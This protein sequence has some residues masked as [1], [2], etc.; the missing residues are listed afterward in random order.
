MSAFKLFFS[1]FIQLLLWTI[2]PFL[3]T[4][5]QTDSLST[6]NPLPSKRKSQLLAVPFVSYSPETA[7]VFGGVGAFYF[8]LAKGDTT[9]R[10]SQIQLIA[11]SSTNGQLNFRPGWELITQNENYIFRGKLSIARFPNKNY[12]LGNDADLQVVDY[13]NGTGETLNYLRYT[14]DRYSVRNS[15]LRKIADNLY[16]GLQLEV[17][18]VY[19]YGVLADSLQYL[20]GQSEIDRIPVEGFRLGAGFNI[21]YD[22]RTNSL[23]PLNGS[24]VEFQSVFYRKW[25]GADFHYRSFSLD[26]RKYINTTQKH[27]LALQ[28]FLQHNYPKDNSNLPLRA[29]AQLGG[30]DLIRGYREGTYQDNSLTV[31]QVEYR[32]PVW[33]FIGVVGFAGVGQVYSSSNQWKWNRFRTGVGGGLR[34][35]ISKR[36]RINFRID[37]AYGLDP[38]SDING[39]QSGFYFFVGEAF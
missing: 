12:G 7:L 36:Q 16:A 5:A 34:F 14:V 4:F 26:A 21:S 11:I 27:T 23:N 28:L 38:L 13:E 1:P 22:S 29:L 3:L 33:K 37:Y 9:S 15:A 35:M 17:E 31:A 30:S 8:D 18:N 20:S 2:C 39:A 24:F 6:Q 25:L 32:M 19:N 10:M